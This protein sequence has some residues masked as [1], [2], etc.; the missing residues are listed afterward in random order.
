MSLKQQIV[1]FG[2]ICGFP[3]A[4]S[5]ATREY[6]D[7]TN[8]EIFYVFNGVFVL[9]LCFAL[10]AMLVRH[11]VQ[12]L[13]VARTLVTLTFLYAIAATRSDLG[14]IMIVVVALV[15]MIIWAKRA[16]SFAQHN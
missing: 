7:K 11:K 3:L 14:P 2:A 4:S 9:G 13:T 1:L 8:P 10:V 15:S 16:E 5:I 6:F 12:L